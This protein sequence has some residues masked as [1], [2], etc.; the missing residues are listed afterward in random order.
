MSKKTN[1]KSKKYKN[2][3]KSLDELLKTKDNTINKINL[4]NKDTQSILTDI[5]DGDINH[6]LI[7]RFSLRLFDLL[8]AVRSLVRVESKIKKVQLKLIE[9]KE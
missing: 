4:I 1:S 9:T 7:G 3:K 8:D 6:Q 2:N 5:L